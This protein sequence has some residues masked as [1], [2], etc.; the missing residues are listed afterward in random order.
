MKVIPPPL[1]G[2]IFIHLVA[3][4]IVT[5]MPRDLGVKSSRSRKKDPAMAMTAT[6][7]HMW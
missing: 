2:G 3:L 6:L 1:P 7:L 4:F 5:A